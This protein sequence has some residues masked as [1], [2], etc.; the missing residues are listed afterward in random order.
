METY[1]QIYK[2]ISKDCDRFKNYQ[3]IQEAIRSIES[4][5]S[6]ETVPVDMA[7]EI[8]YP[9]KEINIKILD[10]QFIIPRELEKIKDE[11]EYSNQILALTENWDN[12][13]AKP[14]D[15][16]VY[17]EAIGLLIKSSTHIHNQVFKVIDVPEINPCPDGSVDLSWITRRA[18]LL[19]N[20]RKTES[21]IL[22]YF[23]G[24]LKN[25]VRPF[26]GSASLDCLD[27]LEGWMR[28]YLI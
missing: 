18:R 23:Y 8:Y 17:I 10:K 25:N 11:I 7:W 26:K 16:D 6:S 15:R 28:M 22:A 24:D 3:L 2:S 4:T 20:V 14:I 5:A 1:P 13:G 12:E 19:I 21:G 9:K 27:H